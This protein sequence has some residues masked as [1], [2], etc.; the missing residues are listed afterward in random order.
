MVN[1]G[2]LHSDGAFAV[3][4]GA[5]LAGGLPVAF[6]GGTVGP[7]TVAVLL[8]QRREEVPF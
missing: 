4:D 5:I 8:V 1:E 6:L 7:G 2:F 3:L